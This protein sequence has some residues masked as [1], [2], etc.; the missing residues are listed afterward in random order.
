MGAGGDWQTP[1]RVVSAE[2]IGQ[3]PPWPCPAGPRVD[4]EVKAIPPALGGA[5][6]GLV[7]SVDLVGG[8]GVSRLLQ[9]SEGAPGV[10]LL[11]GQAH[12]KGPQEDR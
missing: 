6:C 11:A 5:C 10:H 8:L 9:E 1:G 7:F 2:A 12:P 4:T 3:A